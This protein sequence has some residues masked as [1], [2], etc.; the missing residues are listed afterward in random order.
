[1][2]SPGQRDLRKTGANV[3]IALY[4]SLACVDAIP[5][6]GGPENF[7][8]RIS[9]PFLDATGIWQ[10]TWDLFAPSVDKGNHRITAEIFVA[11]EEDPRIWSS[12]EWSEMNCLD[13]FLHS[14][15][16]EFYDRI[17]SSWNEPAQ[18]SFVDFLKRNHEATHE[19]EIVSE[20]HLI[21]TERRIL[22]RETKPEA[23][24]KR[25]YRREFHN[26]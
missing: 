22:I 13:L 6:P 21:S 25:F 5:L 19:G 26:D 1:M 17:R 8:K 18:A 14:R 12:P 2:T 11:G 20:I 3:L 16:I 10:G 4:L 23:T 9:D 15:E 24:V 7:L